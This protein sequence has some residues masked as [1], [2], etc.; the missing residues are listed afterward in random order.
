MVRTPA[1]EMAALPLCVRW[2]EHQLS[3]CIISYFLTQAQS[4]RWTVVGLVTWGVGCGSDTPGVYA[5]VA[6]F[7][8]WINS[9]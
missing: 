9:N 8:N 2:A 5:K 7:R 1:L 6:S 4:G 3:Q